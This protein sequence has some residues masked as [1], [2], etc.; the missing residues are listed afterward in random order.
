MPHGAK[1]KVYPAELVA[2]VERLYAA[3]HTQVEIAAMLRTT[4]KVI[5]K[6]MVRHGLNARVAAKR[7]QRGA[8]NLGWKGAEAGYAAAHLRVQAARGTP[9]L[10]ASCGTTTAKRFEWA[11]ITGN[12]HDVN[13]YKRLCT[14]CHHRMDGTFKNLGRYAERKEV[15]P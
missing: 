3:G 8:K 14:S 6:L 10:C 9:S 11:N 7:D 12:Y 13:D 15:L 1:P 4:Q 5:W 2:E